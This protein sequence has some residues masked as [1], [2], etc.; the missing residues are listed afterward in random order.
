MKQRI[1]F[2]IIM[3]LVLSSMMSCWIT[4]INLGPGV[5]FLDQWMAAFRLAWPV[6]GIIA[7]VMGPVIHNMTRRVVS[8]IS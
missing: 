1:V 7:F 2:A 5:Q 3:S 4:F 6:A 8:L